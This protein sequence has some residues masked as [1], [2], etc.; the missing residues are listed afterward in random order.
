MMD[1]PKMPMLPEP[2]MKR[3]DPLM[4][5]YAFGYHADQLRDLLAAHHAAWEA[6]VAQLRDMV[7]AAVP[8]KAMLFVD[9]S[10]EDVTD[11]A[12]F[13]RCRAETIANI[14]ALFGKETPNDPE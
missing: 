4:N 7:L 3:A 5:V 12:G 14:N 2:A 13:N 9:C 8:E 11:A 1:K 10:P 6:Y